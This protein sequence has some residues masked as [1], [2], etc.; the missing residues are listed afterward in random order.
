MATT[1]TPGRM[2]VIAFSDG[3]DYG[4]LRS[5]LNTD[6]DSTYGWCVGLR[7]KNGDYTEVALFD[8]PEDA[9]GGFT[10]DAD[11]GNWKGEARYFDLDDVVQIIVL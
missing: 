5:V 8:S 1:S 4:T 7:L 9:I 3:A 6:G 2:P 10:W 11:A